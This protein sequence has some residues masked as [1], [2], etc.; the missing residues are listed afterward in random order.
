MSG[1]SGTAPRLRLRGIGYDLGARALLDAVDL[2]LETGEVVALVGPNGAGKSTLLHVL[3]GDSTPSRGT[4]EL[5]GAPLAE[6]P[7][8]RLARR[9]AVLTQANTVSFP[10]T[11]AEVVEMGRAPWEGRDESSDDDALIHAALVDAEVEALADRRMP[12][13]S[14]GERARASY[15]RMLAQDCGIVLLD[16]PTASLD[17]RHQERLLAQLR[18]HASRGGSAVIVLHDLNLACRYADLPIGM[19]TALVGG[20]FFFWL[21]RRTRLSSGGWG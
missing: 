21:L 12:E 2:D 19:L 14:G 20:P 18:R 4:I 13:L 9:R 10:F 7:A 11:V 17:I 15:A 3:A 8:R 5:D 6:M 1:A 16:E